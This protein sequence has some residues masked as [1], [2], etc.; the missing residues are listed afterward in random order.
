Y[1]KRE[2][3]QFALELLLNGYKLPLN[4]L[5]FT[6]YNDDEEAARLW[7]E[8]GV[9]S[10][11]IL[12]FGE[13]DNFWQMGDT[14]PCGPSSEVNYYLGDEPDN[15]EKNRAE[16]VNGAGDETVEIWNLVFMQFERDTSGMLTPLPKPSVDT[17][18]GLERL[19]SVLQ[20]VKSNYETDLI[21]PIIDFISDLTEIAYVYES[22][23]GFA[24]RV[25]ADHAR[26]TAFSIADNMYPGNEGRNY[27]L[28]KI[29]RRAIYQGHKALGVEEEFFYKVTD[30]V[31]EHMRNAYPELESSR[32]FIAEAVRSEEKRF[33][34]TLS[35]G[36]QRL[37]AL[38]SDAEKQSRM[39]ADIELARLYDTFGTPRD[40]IRVSL[41]ER[42]HRIAEEEFNAR[43]DKALIVL[44]KSNGKVTTSKA[45]KTNPVLL[46]L[47]ERHGKTEFTGYDSTELDKAKI[48]AL[49]RDESEVKELRAGEEGEVVLDR[50]PFYAEAGGQV[51]DTGT[52]SISPRNAF[53]N[54]SKQTNSPGETVHNT[55]APV[56]VEITLKNALLNVSNT[57][58]PVP[59]FNVHHVKVESGSVNVDDSVTAEVNAELRHATQRNHT[60]THL[61][62]A[63]LREVLGTHVKQAGSLVAPNRLRFDFTHYQPLT[64]EEMAEIE[65]KINIT[66][67]SDTP[68]Q[69]DLMPLEEA[70]KSGAM[71]LFGEKYSSQ[72]R[73]L[74]VPGFSREL[75]GGT[76]VRTTSEIGIFKIVSEEAIASGIRRIEAITG[77]DSVIRFQESERLLGAIGERLKVARNDLP[78]AVEKLQDELKRARRENDELRLKLA[79]RTVS[80]SAAD[81]P[82]K[83]KG[84]NVLARDASE[85]NAAGLR[86]LSDVLMSR[87]K[88][89]VV[90]LGRAEPG[91]KASLIVR[92]S[93]DLRDRVPAGAVIRELAPIIGGRGG[94]RPD[95]AEGG[96]AKASEL[97]VALNASFEVIE[98]MLTE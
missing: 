38:F 20:G 6:V 31:I 16:F 89:G 74:T 12:P 45:A 35:T 58:A 81:E 50:T 36:L 62:H 67:L 8:A 68:V 22:A 53:L 28:R 39:P 70:M 80:S 51:G 88:S 55:Y 17:G 65:D 47:A 40:L 25:I 43:F 92:T 84:V 64:H 24:M 3:I 11:R 96:G 61:L 32:S 19:A 23:E 56:P 75:C 1:Y 13:K 37:D 95:M 48:I 76:H 86:Q 44:Q 60:A 15:P 5:W 90:I 73:V 2:A 27:V 26:A 21:R 93:D 30:F 9:S 83:I 14:G 29:M 87:I 79:T 63:A 46:E 78:Q 98:K 69:T 4:R 54:L 72:V 57:Y 33:S 41:E 34:N 91:G 18:A 7:E 97:S 77:A 59:G 82:R 52:I 10:S 94:G 49:V 85:L 71:A 42:G 66:I